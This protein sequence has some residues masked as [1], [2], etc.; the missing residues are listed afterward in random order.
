MFNFMKFHKYKLEKVALAITIMLAIFVPDISH[1][2]G[3]EF[4]VKSIKILEQSCDPAADPLLD[5]Y[6]TE[7]RFKSCEAQGIDINNFELTVK[8]KFL[9]DNG[10]EE[11]IKRMGIGE[12]KNYG[13]I[14]VVSPLD[15]DKIC[16]Y[17][18]LAGTSGAALGTGYMPFAPSTGLLGGVGAIVGAIIPIDKADDLYSGDTESNSSNLA[19]NCVYLPE[20]RV[21][22]VPPSWSN[23]ISK[24]CTEYD[25]SDSMFRWPNGK[26]RSFIGV[27][28]QCIEETFNNIFTVEEGKNPDG[29]ARTFFSQAQAHMK[30]IV[31]AIIILYIT[32][33]GYRMTVMGGGKV[34]ISQKEWFWVVLKI[35]LVI[36]FAAGSGMTQVLPALQTTTKGL[37]AI[38][39]EAGFGNKIDSKKAFDDVS[40]AAREYDEA[41]N[42]LADARIAY[43]KDPANTSLVKVLNEAMQVKNEAESKL[44][45]AKAVSDSYGYNYCDFRNVPYPNGQDFMK[46]WDMID[47]KISKYLGIGDNTSSPG[48]PQLINAV[49]LLTMF[50]IMS[51]LVTYVIAGGFA[52]AYYVTILGVILACLVMFL[53]Y[54]LLIILR[55]VQSYLIASISLV[56]LTFVSPL[57]I[58]AVLFEKTK[59]SFK[60]WV[61]LL[62]GYTLQPVILFAVVAFLMGM[63]D[64]VIFGHNYRFVPMGVSSNNSSA[65]TSSTVYDNKMCM[66]TEKTGIDVCS[67]ADFIKYSG[68]EL[69]CYDENVLACL[70]NKERYMNIAWEK[71]DKYTVDTVFIMIFMLKLFL[72]AFI[73]HYVIKLIDDIV[74]RITD[75]PSVSKESSVPN[76]DLVGVATEG[77]KKSYETADKITKLAGAGITKAR[78]GGGGATDAGDIKGSLMKSAEGEGGS[79]LKGKVTGVNLG[80]DKDKTGSGDKDKTDEA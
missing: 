69:K 13:L 77:G 51:F 36:F 65:Y 52:I 15:G 39:I 6:K 31:F 57:I 18:V 56:I 12:R 68:V 30:K 49:F 19:K 63:F 20:P 22:L 14:D 46:I 34:N 28:V 32:L 67:S 29:K 59:E 44:S 66:K 25:S 41:V 26:N 8:I 53:V 78:S 23:M 64:S 37:S 60:I 9:G 55:M 80:V 27:T 47:C 1:S 70:F 17:A 5:S 11:D 43:A 79:A 61:K 58:P 42:D 3:T 74:A 76:M 38:V 72:I 4:A 24:V 21:Q 10:E 40:A 33:F 73:A 2:S 16:I 50:I 71:S 7:S 45:K 54:L 35:A 48:S 75:T 62:I